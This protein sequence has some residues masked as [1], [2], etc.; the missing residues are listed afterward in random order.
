VVFDSK[1]VLIQSIIAGK[2]IV[3]SINKTNLDEKGYVTY[4]TTNGW[5]VGKKI[6]INPFDLSDEGNVANEISQRIKE[7]KSVDAFT[8]AQSMYN[9]FIKNYEKNFNEKVK[10]SHKAIYLSDVTIKT[11]NGRTININFFV[12]FTDQI[13]GILPGKVDIEPL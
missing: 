1:S 7:G 8:I 12:L 2:D 3:N 9:G 4:L 5:I 10:D 11:V 13:I 6:E